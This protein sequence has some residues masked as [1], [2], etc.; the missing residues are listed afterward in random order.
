MVWQVLSLL[1]EGETEQEIFQ[2]FPNLPESAIK[3]ALSYAT[4]KVKKVSYIPFV[5]LKPDS[6]ANFLT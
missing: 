3:D 6:N 4:S 1:E 5:N 2:A